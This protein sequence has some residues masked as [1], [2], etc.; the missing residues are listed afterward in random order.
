MVLQIAGSHVASL[1]GW[2]CCFPWQT[3]HIPGIS[4]S[5]GSP[6][7]LWLH[8]HSFSHCSFRGCLKGLLP[9]STLPGLSDFSLN[10]HDPI[11]LAFCMPAKP[12]LRGQCQVSY[13]PSSSQR[14]TTGASECLDDWTLGNTSLGDPVHRVHQSSGTLLGNEH[15]Q[16]HTYPYTISSVSLVNL[17]D[18]N[19]IILING[20]T[21]F[22]PIGN[23]LDWWF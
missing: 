3:F 20:A 1:L 9:W 2:L 15:T 4:N 7:H 19:P 8:P 13:E 17:T 18:T 6:L 12:A 11:T 5:L 10:F 22:I 14:G 16:T 21:L 23:K